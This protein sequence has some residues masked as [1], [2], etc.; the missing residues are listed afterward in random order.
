MN[1]TERIK[2]KKKGKREGIL[3]MVFLF[4][5]ILYLILLFKTG[6][7]E[8]IRPPEDASEFQIGL[9]VAIGIGTFMALL[10]GALLCSSKSTLTLQLLQKDKE[11][12]MEERNKFHAKL[13]WDCIIDKDFDE[14]KR[15]YNLDNFI[16]GS[17]RVLCNGILMGIATQTPIDKDW[18]T[19]VN[20]RMDSYLR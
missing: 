20:E 14:A 13:F 9:R 5:T 2:V 8:L 12:M 11:L 17:F 7:G 4:T 6:L 1:R 3:S 15:L 16:T 19:G 18:K 10:L